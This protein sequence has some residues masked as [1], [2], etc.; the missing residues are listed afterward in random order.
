M[1]SSI[2]EH[3]STESIQPT[4]SK[5]AHSDE[6]QRINDLSTETFAQSN[7]IKGL[8]NTEIIRWLDLEAYC[9]R[10]IRS[11]TPLENL[12]SEVFVDGQANSIG[13]PC[14]K[15]IQA[16]KDEETLAPIGIYYQALGKSSFFQCS[17]KM[18]Q[19]ITKHRA[20]SSYAHPHADVMT[21]PV[22][23]CPEE[24][25]VTISGD[26][27]CFVHANT[28]THPFNNESWIACQVP[29]T[30]LA[31]ENFYKMLDDMPA[32]SIV[33][34]LAQSND[35]K[36]YVL[37]GGQRQEVP[38]CNSL[39]QNKTE[40][41]QYWP[42]KGEDIQLSGSLLIKNQSQSL[43]EDE[44]ARIS[45]D[46]FTG[47]VEA[48]DVIKELENHGIEI[49]KLCIHNKDTNTIK[50]STMLRYGD[51]KDFK[52]SNDSSRVQLLIRLRDCLSKQNPQSSTVVHCRA[53]V[54]RTG[55]FVATSFALQ[56]LSALTDMEK[57]R[58]IAALGNNGSA[59]H[60]M[61]RYSLQYMAAKSEYYLE[62]LNVL[63]FSIVQQLRLDRD[64]SN[65]VQSS[66]QF[67][68]IFSI[69]QSYLKAN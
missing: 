14:P 16:L 26:S 66:S 33:V 1:I 27:D 56:C 32:D 34:N 11:T 60:K 45:Q 18:I 64:P 59:Y 25:R 2:N 19:Q 69:I 7:D 6:N 44:K 43:S 65:T 9:P 13:A 39:I 17:R 41:I 50:S 15:I 49:H 38:F 46:L 29:L 4:T 53:G 51:W 67:N 55:T 61:L 42:E 62:G 24:T 31:V 58:E 57:F 35:N 52:G 48:R 23:Y 28:F 40:A 8:S 10:I 3:R 47:T 21:I 22:I 68:S 54:G 36:R 5:H 12:V 63:V 20:W 37:R 30:D